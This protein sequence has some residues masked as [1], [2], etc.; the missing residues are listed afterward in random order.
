MQAGF[1]QAHH[2]WW[3]RGGGWEMKT[4]V[5]LEFYMLLSSVNFTFFSDHNHPLFWIPC[6]WLWGE[7]Q[8]L[9]E[10]NQL[11][12]KR[13]ARKWML[14]HHLVRGRTHKWSWLWAV[15]LV[16]TGGWGGCGFLFLGTRPS[17][18][19]RLALH[20]KDTSGFGPLMLCFSQSSEKLPS[21]SGVPVTLGRGG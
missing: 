13:N 2:W 7:M 17:L 21:E 11:C 12:W 4:S 18:M 1:F 8:V 3:G 16:I 9:K 15:M 19:Y 14:S 10:E 5:P 20:E 6:I